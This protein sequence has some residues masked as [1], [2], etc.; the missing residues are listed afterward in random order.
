MPFSG[1]AVALVTLFAAAGALLAEATA[2]LAAGLAARGVTAIVVAGSTGE[3]AT[4]DEDER[5]DLVRAVRAAVPADVP[6]LAGTG[7]PRRAR[8]CA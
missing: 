6:V 5:D 3:A 7:A 8:R 2:E 4:L 1:V